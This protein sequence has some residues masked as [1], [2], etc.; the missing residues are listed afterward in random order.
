MIRSDREYRSAAPAVA[1]QPAKGP[2]IRFAEGG[3]LPGPVGAP[4]FAMVHG[5]ETIRNPSQ[6]A[7]IG[8]DTYIGLNV[9]PITG[10]VIVETLTKFDPRYKTLF[11][12]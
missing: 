7:K 3:I 9:N 11:R 5:G 12:V 8:G 10:D 6:E 1:G 4:L 2:V